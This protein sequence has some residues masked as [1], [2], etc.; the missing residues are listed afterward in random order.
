MVGRQGKRKGNLVKHKCYSVTV[1][2]VVAMEAFLRMG[3]V[4]VGKVGK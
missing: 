1:V 3:K 4:E 2:P